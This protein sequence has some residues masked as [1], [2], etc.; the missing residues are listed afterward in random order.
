MGASSWLV[1]G[2][3][4]NQVPLQLGAVRTVCAAMVRVCKKESFHKRQ[5]DESMMTP[6]A[7]RLSGRRWRRIAT[8]DVVAGGG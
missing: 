5:G 7:A 4:M 2:R 6:R 3:I 1:D 8:I